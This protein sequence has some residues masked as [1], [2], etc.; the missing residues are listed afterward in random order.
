VTE[1]S[2]WIALV[3]AVLASYAG[4]A[5]VAL[6]TFSRARLTELFASRN[7]AETMHTLLARRTRLVMLTGAMRACLHLVVLVG[8]LVWMKA[9][10]PEAGAALRYTMALALAAVLVTVLG[11]ALPASLG[12]VS[13]ERILARSTRGFLLVERLLAPLTGLLAAVDTL[14]QRVTGAHE[15]QERS[16]N[17]IT[18]EVLHVVEAHN[19][20]QPVEEDQKEMLEAVFEFPSTTAGEIMTPRTDVK[21]IEVA[22]DLDHVKSAVLEYGHSRIPVYEESLDQIVGIFY[23]KDLIAYLGTNETFELRAILRDA[24]LVPESKPVRDLLSD[25]KARKVHLAIVLDEYGGT[26]GLVT[27]EDILEELVGEIQDEYEPAEQEPDAERI[28]DHTFEVDARMEVDEFNDR[29]GMRL[30]E[31]ADYETV[32]GFVF[33]TLG[34]IPERGESFEHDGAR[35]TVIDAER[36]KVRR[37]CVELLE[38]AAPAAGDGEEARDAAG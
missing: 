34:H 7:L 36:T 19:G 18:D 8:M 5:Q 29:L 30:P 15:E 20:E 25:F 32:G 24:L 3:A 26:A 21:G 31:D 38:G 13:G 23:V 33:A 27:I 10:A 17:E 2:L 28:D 11:V 16:D 37:V 9:Q 6:R 22:A 12:R 14:A 4:A 1:P 35:V